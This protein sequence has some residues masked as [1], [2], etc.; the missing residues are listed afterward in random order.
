MTTVHLF[1]RN[2]YRSFHDDSAFGKMILI[3]GVLII[4]T[5]VFLRTCMHDHSVKIYSLVGNIKMTRGSI[6][7]NTSKMLK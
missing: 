3:Q 7:C 5:H 6:S 4:T 1:S 2:Q